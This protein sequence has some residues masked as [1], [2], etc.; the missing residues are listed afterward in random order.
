MSQTVLPIT[1]L[2]LNNYAVQAGDLAVAMTALD[3]SAGN[4]IQSTGKEILLVQNTDT[5]AHNL[6]ISSVADTLGRTDTSLS[7]YSVPANSFIA[8]ELNQINGWA[9]NGLILILAA[10][11]LLKAVAL[12]FT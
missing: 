12:R 5:V 2:K 7:A 10:S 8:I 3:A 6:Q 4:S 11:N 9:Q 1:T